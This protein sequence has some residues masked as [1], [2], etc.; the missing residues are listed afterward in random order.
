MKNPSALSMM[1][2]LVLAAMQVA[3]GQNLPA[4]MAFPDCDTCG[5]LQFLD[6]S[7]PCL[8]EFPAVETIAANTHPD[9]VGRPVIAQSSAAALGAL[10]LVCMA[11]RKR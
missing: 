11:L 4:S 6:V 5:N 1:A 9:P 2:V 10:G 8:D 3:T 7:F